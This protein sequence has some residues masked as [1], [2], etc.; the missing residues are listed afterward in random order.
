M[1]PALDAATGTPLWQ[2]TGPDGQL[3]LSGRLLVQEQATFCSSD[4]LALRP[5]ESG[6][7]AW[8]AA[9]RCATAGG[10]AQRPWRRRNALR[11]LGPALCQPPWHGGAPPW[12]SG[13]PRPTPANRSRRTEGQAALRTKGRLLLH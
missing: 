1:V 11:C 2:A 4:G 7:R 6:G 12:H 5:G 3:V 13:T 9:S 8:W 10:V